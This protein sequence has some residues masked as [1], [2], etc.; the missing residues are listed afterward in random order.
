MI[1]ST[2]RSLLTLDRRER[3]ELALLGRFRSYLNI[4]G[5]TQEVPAFLWRESLHDAPDSAQQARD[6][7]LGGLTEMRLQFAKG[8][9]D[10]IEVGRIGRQIKQCRS[11]CLYCLPDAGDLVDRQI[12]HH[13]NVAALDGRNKALFHISKKQGSIHGTLKDERCGHPAQ[14][15]AADKCDD[16]PVPVR[17]VID[18]P[19]ADRPAAT[20][21][22]HGAVRPS[23]IDKDQPCRVEHTLLA[24]PASARADHIGAL[25]LGCVQSFF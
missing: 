5:V 8:H 11:R 14:T 9:L 1:S 15:Q 22:H 21:S 16:L 20:N 19:L 23:L 2:A 4:A 3:I 25:L 24:H 7:V 10:R 12:V 17:C 6:G 13:D 18:Q